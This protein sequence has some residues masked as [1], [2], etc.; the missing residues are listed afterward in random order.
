MHGCEW[1]LVGAPETF[2]LVAVHFLG[3]GPSLR[4]AQHD[5][6]PAR[7]SGL[8]TG[9]SFLL[10]AA[11]LENTI[12]QRCGHLLV[13]HRDIVPFHEMRRP[14]VTLEEALHFLVRD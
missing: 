6:G 3:T 4:S 10:N 13:H 5:H 9:A 12:L 7:S 8:V 1:Y 11:D 14:A 2:H